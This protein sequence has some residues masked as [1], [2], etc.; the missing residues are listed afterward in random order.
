MEITPEFRVLATFAL[1]AG[2]LGAQTSPAA[3]AFDVASIKSTRASATRE[4]GS[5]NRLRKAP[6]FQRPARIEV[7][8]GS[9]GLFVRF[10]LR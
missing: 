7:P 5:P 9:S 1:M 2:S 6:V 10:G 4:G 3:P 8:C